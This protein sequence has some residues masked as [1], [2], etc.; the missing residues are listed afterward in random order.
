MRIHNQRDFW[1]GIMFLVIGITFM[2]LSAQYQ[3]GSAAKMGPGYFPLVLGGLMAFLG[4][5]IAISGMR[6]TA[7]GEDVKLLPVGWKELILVLV[8]VALFAALL[9]PMGVIV[10]L[11]AMVIVASLASHEFHWFATVMIC[12]I[13]CVMC[14]AIFV[15][16]LELQFSVWPSFLTK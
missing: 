10:A 11:V 14:W 6:R 9:N 2:I 8:A 7:N 12:V 16:G 3:I 13:L 15:V 1:A 5:L 4:L